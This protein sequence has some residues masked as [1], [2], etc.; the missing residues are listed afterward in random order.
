MPN[1]NESTP[2]RKGE[3]KAAAIRRY[4]TLAGEMIGAPVGTLVGLTLGGNEGALLGSTDAPFFSYALNG[5][6]NRAF[7]QRATVR[8]VGTLGYAST[9]ISELLAEGKTLRDDGFFDEMPDDRSA[10]SEIFEAVVIAAQTEHEE[11]KLPFMGNLLAYLAVTPGISRAYANSLVKV[12][13]DLSFTQLCLMSIYANGD[14]W[15][16]RDRKYDLGNLELR[17]ASL[18]LGLSVVLDQTFVM[19][20]RGLVRNSAEFE[21]VLPPHPLNVVPANTVIQGLTAQLFEFM[22]LDDIDE[23]E[24]KPLIEHL[25]WDGSISEFDSDP[26]A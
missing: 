10:A 19:W 25:Q 26:D 11:K 6:V 16:L 12:A 7:D 22:R 1:E 9:R 8:V 24:L 20:Q 3:T 4:T 2:C 18:S 21:T 23:E 5:I 14:R 17:E 13:S 15:E